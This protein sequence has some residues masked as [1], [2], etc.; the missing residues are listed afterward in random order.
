MKK[1]PVL[2]L[3]LVS[4]TVL[5]TKPSEKAYNIK[6]AYIKYEISGFDHG[7]SEVLFDDFGE[8]ESMYSE[9]SLKVNDTEMKT[10]IGTIKKNDKLFTL[11]FMSRTYFSEYIEL[12]EE[13]ESKKK[14]K[15]AKKSL[16]QKV[17]EAFDELSEE[18]QKIEKKEKIKNQVI[19]TEMVLDKECEVLRV[20]DGVVWIY[21]GIIL[22]QIKFLNKD[23][24]IYEAVIFEEN[25]KIASDA[26]TVPEGFM[27]VENPMNKLFES[28]N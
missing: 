8:N 23:K 17:E 10:M 16:K 11:N 20:S 13:K 19:G 14:V 15:P 24:L 1:L 5:A 3:I 4:T 28:R 22:R 6:S 21:K 26:F 2:L 18:A 12:E 27:V 25:P 9:I 7:F